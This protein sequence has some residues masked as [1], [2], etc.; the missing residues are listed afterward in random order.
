MRYIHK[1]F[2]FLLVALLLV[3]AALPVAAA[4]EEF[5]IAVESITEIPNGKTI[6]LEVENNTG[7]QI[8]FGWVRSCEVLVTT[9]EGTYSMTPHMLKVPQGNSTHELVIPHCPGE[10]E[11][12]VLT[13]L[14]LLSDDGLPN[15]Q[16]ED[17]VIY[18][19]AEGITSFT[20][21][22]SALS[23][24]PTFMWVGLGIFAV[25][26][27]GIICVIAFMID[28]HK[29]A[30]AAKA[31][32]FAPFTGAAVP[33]MAQ[34]MHNTAHQQF[35]QQINQQQF[36]DFTRQSGTT[37]DMGGFIPPPPPPPTGL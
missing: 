27:I 16:M 17:V 29:K 36:S 1:L 34:Q 32:A 12:I 31:N 23:G 18:D 15:E 35:N 22:F 30:T 9:D 26:A 19:I 13:D 33:D 5:T 24:L 3:G 10:V 8:S 37:M 4:K 28:K 25:V 6:E 11:T 21:E 14:R 2:A 20:G 7:S